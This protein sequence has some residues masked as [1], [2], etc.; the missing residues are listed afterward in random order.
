MYARN[1]QCL[2]Q[3]L[4]H[5]LF[6]LLEEMGSAEQEVILENNQPVVPEDEVT[7]TVSCDVSD[8]LEDKKIVENEGLLL[9]CFQ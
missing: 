7:T 9:Q 6:L 8:H 2:Q 4:Q 1:V 5:G 3:S